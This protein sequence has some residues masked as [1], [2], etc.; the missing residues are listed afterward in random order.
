M[1]KGPGQHSTLTWVASLRVL[2]GFKTPPGV[3]TIAGVHLLPVW[4]YAVQHE[5]PPYVGLPDVVSVAFLISLVGG[6]LSSLYCE[7]WCNW[8]HVNNLLNQG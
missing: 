4:L 6:R 5:L 8:R 7:L 2:T 3:W 1:A